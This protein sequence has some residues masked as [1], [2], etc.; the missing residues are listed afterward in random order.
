MPRVLWTAATRASGTSSKDDAGSWEATITREG[1]LLGK[2]VSCALA[3]FNKTKWNQVYGEGTT[4]PCKFARAS[5]SHKKAACKLYLDQCMANI[6]S[7]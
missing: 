4:E 2:E 5:L 1:E 7:S 6:L 3:D